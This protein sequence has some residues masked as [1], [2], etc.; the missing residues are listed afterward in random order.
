MAPVS[1]RK[2]S[3]PS[4]GVTMNVLRNAANELETTTEVVL[5][6]DEAY[7]RNALESVG[8]ERRGLLQRL[9]RVRA[10]ERE[11]RPSD[12]PIAA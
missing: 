4:K 11:D 12:V 1:A 8:W 2:R 3:K 9:V 7:G 6:A 10:A 5:A